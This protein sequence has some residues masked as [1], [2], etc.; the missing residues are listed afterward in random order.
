MDTELIARN[1]LRI[2]KDRGKTQEAV[3]DGAGLSRAG[4][5]AIE[6]G[7]AEPRPENLR[8]IAGVL[9]VPLRELVTPAPKLER[10]R[11][12]S[13]KRLKS[14]DQIL[15]DVARWLR[16][17]QELEEILDARQPHA[18]APLWERLAASRGVGLAQVAAA[19]REHFGLGP[20]EPIHDICGLLE[21]RGVKVRAVVVANDAFLGLSVAED[22]GGPAV[23]VNTWDRL[24]VEHW[25]YSAVHELGHLLLHLGAYDVSV[26]DEDDQQEREAEVFASHFLMPDAPFWSEWEAAA[27]LGLYDRVLKVKRVFRVSW[28][29]V[30][31][32]VS[33]RLPP[34]DRSRLWRHMAAE[35]QRRQG[36]PLLKLTEPAGVTEDVFGEPRF[37][38][39]AGAEPAGLDVH[40]FQ[41][42]RL[43]RLVR[44]AVEEE[45][46]SLSRGAEILGLGV[47]EM[48][49][50]AASWVA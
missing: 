5:R 48:R 29:A 38:A 35:H 30:L 8:A 19:T 22:H 21:A 25:I 36:R 4:Y 43:A 1:L 2:R 26:Q 12:R 9:G 34:G 7:H 16:S 41:G 33:E 37:L 49:D 42:D 17:F 11:F 24:A 3:A 23:V 44:R 39:S 31:Y 13:L 27:G 32:R 20:R 46:I 6:K 15:V 50:L 18:L 47:A 28:R 10:V 14:R 45:A 40:D